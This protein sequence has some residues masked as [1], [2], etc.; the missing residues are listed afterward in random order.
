MK[1]MYSAVKL[2]RPPLIKYDKKFIREIKNHITYC[3]LFK[4]DQRSYIH[5]ISEKYMQEM[6]KKYAEH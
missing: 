3:L 6:I 4:Y 1:K 5:K 2:L